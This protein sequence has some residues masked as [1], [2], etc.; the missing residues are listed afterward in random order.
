MLAEFPRVMVV[1]ARV[2]AEFSRVMAVCA[3]VLRV[4]VGIPVNSKV[5]TA[6]LTAW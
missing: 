6:L 3:R 4:S 5:V 2:L 1:Y